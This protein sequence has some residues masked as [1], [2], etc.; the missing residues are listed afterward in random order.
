MHFFGLT[1]S[2]MFIYM[3]FGVPMCIYINTGCLNHELNYEIFVVLD[4]MKSKN[5]IKSGH[6]QLLSEHLG[7]EWKEIG[8]FIGLTTGETD[9]I[10]DKYKTCDEVSGHTAFIFGSKP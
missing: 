2:I 3:L 5:T 6:L 1:I 9:L 4:L 7:K 8:S 10:E